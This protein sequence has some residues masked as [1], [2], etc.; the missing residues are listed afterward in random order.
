MTSWSSL[1]DEEE[2]DAIR[3]VRRIA[4]EEFV[5]LSEAHILLEDELKRVTGEL[6][7]AEEKISRL[8]SNN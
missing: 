8:E 5:R 6:R 3:E 1:R 7:K 2:S 4:W